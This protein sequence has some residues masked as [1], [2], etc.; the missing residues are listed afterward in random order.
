MASQICPWSQEE[1]LLSQIPCQDW[2]SSWF[3][4]GWTNCWTL[5]TGWNKIYIFF[6]T[7]LVNGP[8]TFLQYEGMMGEFKEIHKQSE[9][10]KTSGFNTSDI[11]KDIASMEDEKEQ[12]IKRVERLKRKVG[13]FYSIK[14][15]VAQAT[16]NMEQCKFQKLSW[17]IIMV[18]GFV[19]TVYL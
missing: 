12:L 1:G 14:K 10:L 4:R 3:Y 19:I 2:H 15:S 7:K 18:N 8:A 11:K 17:I 6:L 9:M 5:S 13:R 16:W